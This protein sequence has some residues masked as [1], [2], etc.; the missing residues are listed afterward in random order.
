MW[1]DETE[2]LKDREPENEVRDEEQPDDNEKRRMVA[3]SHKYKKKRQSPSH[4]E[5]PRTRPQ[6]RESDPLSPK[7]RVVED[8]DEG[9]ATTERHQTKPQEDKKITDAKGRTAV[10]TIAQ[11][12]QM[13]DLRPVGI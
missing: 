10:I 11:C 12:S 5:E 7:D 9:M 3:S 1:A 4:T 6:L 2:D 13:E 8:T